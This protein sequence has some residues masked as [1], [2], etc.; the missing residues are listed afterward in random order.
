M[1]QTGYV[2]EVIEVNHCSYIDALTFC[3]NL[4]PS[5]LSFSQDLVRLLQGTLAIAEKDDVNATKTITHKSMQALTNL[6]MVS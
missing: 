3:F 2:L 4:D 5:F 1:V 6:R